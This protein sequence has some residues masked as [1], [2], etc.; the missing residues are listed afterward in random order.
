MD[1]E[2]IYRRKHA[3]LKRAVAEAELLDAEDEKKAMAARQQKRKQVTQNKEQQA[4]KE[5]EGRRENELVFEK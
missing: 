3:L 5:R 2:E 1:R 4:E